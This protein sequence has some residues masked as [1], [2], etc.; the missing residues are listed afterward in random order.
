M[1]MTYYAMLQE[2]AEKRAEDAALISTSGTLT[3]GAYLEAIDRLA[4]GLLA[5]G[6]TSGVRVCLLA[7]NSPESFI[8]F[9][10]CACTGAIAFPINWRFSPGEIETVLRLAEPQMLIVDPANLPTVESLALDTIDHR[11][12]F[13]TELP[14]GWLPFDTLMSEADNDFPAV[15]GDD[16][17]IL[18]STAAVEGV[19]RAAT[20]SH[21]NL[22]TAGRQL[23]ESLELTETDRHLA[24]MPLYHVTGLG[25]SL[26]ALQAGGA[27]VIQER[28]DPSEAVTLMDQHQVTLLASFPPVLA[29]LLE[30]REAVGASWASLRYVLGLDAP[31][32][33]QQLLS[34][35]SAG[36]WTGYGQSESSGIVTLI[37]VREKPGAVGKPLPVVD[38]RCFDDKGEEVP[39]GSPGE[40][41]VRG[42]LVFL[43]YWADEDA[44]RYASRF[45]W[46]HTGDTGRF[47]EEGYLYYLGRKPEKE[48]IKSGGENVYPAEVEFA[49]AALPE[50]QAVCVFGV[51]DE[52]W[53]EAVKAVVE[54]KS[55]E[56]LREEQV[57]EA[58]T[59]RIAAYKK[60]RSVLFIEALPRTPEGQIDREAVKAAYGA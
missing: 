50:I 26:A 47:D 10:A 19:P 17:F 25:L 18:L 31:E 41:V 1:D 60:P 24:A 48:L 33:I 7:Q 14:Q 45:G 51:P 6:I 37:D 58:V 40:I 3:Y 32:V 36:F 54:L 9:G 39:I 13:G 28:F 46:H 4:G 12:G 35:S 56:Q 5:R 43:G 21:R 52:T 8:L 29:S 23:V 20:L 2:M 11:V 59:E 55:G 16:A 49:I 57:I 15:G 38:V 42:P 30:A 22:L 27:N 34:A 44:T 53:G